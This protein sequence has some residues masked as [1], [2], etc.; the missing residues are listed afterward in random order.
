MQAGPTREGWCHACP[1]AFRSLLLQTQPCPYAM[2][3][4][5]PRFLTVP[6]PRGGPL[7]RVSTPLASARI[8]HVKAPPVGDAAAVDVVLEVVALLRGEFDCA[9]LGELVEP[10]MVLRRQVVV[11]KVP[12]SRGSR[13]FHLRCAQVRA[14]GDAGLRRTRLDRQ[15]LRS[16]RPQRRGPT[17]GVMRVRPAQQSSVVRNRA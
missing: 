1:K 6:A 17:L 5:P 10:G 11:G 9:F 7:L 14:R 13:D 15:R 16:R 2:R 12:E 4:C 8:I 3:L